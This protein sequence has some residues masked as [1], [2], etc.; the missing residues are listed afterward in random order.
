MLKPPWSCF[1]EAPSDRGQAPGADAR[2]HG[3]HLPAAL[4][5][6]G[7]AATPNTVVQERPAAC[8]R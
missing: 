7:Y 8:H 5:G 6:V 4:P 2:V 1:S 3:A